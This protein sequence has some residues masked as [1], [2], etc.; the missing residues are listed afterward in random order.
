VECPDFVRY[1]KIADDGYLDDQLAESIAMARISFLCHGLPAKSERVLFPV[2]VD[3]GGR[4][5]E[6]HGNQ[7]DRQNALVT[8]SLWRQSLKLLNDFAQ[9]YRDFDPNQLDSAVLG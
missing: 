3:A 6:C 1:F 2:Y 4:T 5:W 8:D 7:L 9:K